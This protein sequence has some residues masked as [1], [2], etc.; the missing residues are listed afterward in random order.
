MKPRSRLRARV[1][2]R[3][4]LGQIA[5]A[6]EGLG[7]PTIMDRTLAQ[8]HGAAY[9]HLAAF[10]ID[11][12]RC[13]LLEEELAEA[14]AEQ[15]AQVAEHPF[16]WEVFLTAYYVV[17]SIDTGQPSGCELIEAACLHVLDGDPAAA[18][19]GSQ[20][21][22]AVHDALQRGLLPEQLQTIFRSW[23]GGRKQLQ[24][25]LDPLWAEAETQVQR[26]SLRCLALPLQ[27]PPA[28]PTVQTLQAMARGELPL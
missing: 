27:P 8:A 20:L 22:F 21:V 6:E 13:Y 9:V 17:A 16:G 23:R 26:L 14:A 19:L 18:P 5:P 10:C 7:A 28:P 12:D 3:K 15:G 1:A 24:R 2:D 4:R 25:A 11:I